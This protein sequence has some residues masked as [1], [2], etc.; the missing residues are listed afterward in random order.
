MADN[1]DP[2]KP[3]VFSKLDIK[4]GFWRM[5][6]LA[7]DAWNFCYVLPAGDGKPVDID[8]TE[9]VL[10][11]ALQMGWCES[12]LFFCAALET[13]REVI[14]LLVRQQHELPPHPFENQMQV[15]RIPDSVSDL[16]ATLIEVFVYTRTP[17]SPILMYV[18]RHT[19]SVP[20]KRGDRAWQWRR[21]L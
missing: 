4:D 12:P 16:I 20:D 6:V 18:A 2:D 21:S 7:A 11:H 10:P 9:I 19:F 14:R 17:H 13:A 15:D 5:V 3:F 8:N 1:Y